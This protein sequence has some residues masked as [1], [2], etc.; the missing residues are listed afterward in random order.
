MDAANKGQ[1]ANLARKVGRL[2]RS[3]IKLRLARLLA[4]LV[5]LW[6]AGEALAAV[7]DIKN[8]LNSTPVISISNNSYCELCG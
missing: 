3:G 2:R 8:N 5:L 1:N 7:C 6:P 4:V